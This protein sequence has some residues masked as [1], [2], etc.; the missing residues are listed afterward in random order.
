MVGGIRL[1][2][3][4]PSWSKYKEITPVQ[5]A[6]E[7]PPE[8]KLPNPK[9]HIAQARGVG[10][11]FGGRYDFTEQKHLRENPGPGKYNNANREEFSMIAEL[12]ENLI[13]SRQPSQTKLGFH[14]RQ[15]SVGVYNTINELSEIGS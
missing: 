10:M 14:Q 4:N 7:V 2:D 13:S 5:Y 6:R 11:G 9:K 3:N 1:K 15:Q 12:K 8:Q